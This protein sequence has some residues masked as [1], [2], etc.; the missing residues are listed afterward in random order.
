MQLFDLPIRTFQRSRECVRTAGEGADNMFADRQALFCAEMVM[1][2]CGCQNYH[3]REW[4]FT[5][6]SCSGAWQAAISAVT[7][8]RLCQ[9]APFVYGPPPPFRVFGAKRLAAGVRQCR[10]PARG[11]RRGFATRSPALMLHQ[12]RYGHRRDASAADGGVNGGAYPKMVEPDHR[13]PYQ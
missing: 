3:V 11:D 13:H 6:P 4:L 7:P 12:C 2:G 9:P 1:S 10:A 8:P 5:G